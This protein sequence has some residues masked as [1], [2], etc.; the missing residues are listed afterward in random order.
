MDN[1]NTEFVKR[2]LISADYYEDLVEITLLWQ[3]IGR[4]ITIDEL[5]NDGIDMFIT[6]FAKNNKSFRRK[7]KKN[8]H[9]KYFNKLRKICSEKRLE[10]SKQG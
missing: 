3:S 9:K 8:Q 4:D 1:M 7:S 2:T 5:I 6:S 10:I